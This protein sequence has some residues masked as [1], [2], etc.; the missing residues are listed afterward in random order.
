MPTVQIKRGRYAP[1]FQVV[2]SWLNAASALAPTDRKDEAVKFIDHAILELRG[3]RLEV[4]A[5]KR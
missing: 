2:R 5:G 1:R 3:L 4:K